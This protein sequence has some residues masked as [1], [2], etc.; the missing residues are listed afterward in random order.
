[1]EKT[2][3]M[4]R[5]K[6]DNDIEEVLE[7]FP[8]IVLTA[9]NK[10]KVLSGEVDIF[11]NANVYLE[12]FNIKVV[13][14]SRYPYQFPRLFEIGN[15]L[16][17]VPDRHISEDG[18]C[19]VCSLQEENLAAQRGMTIKSFF[20]K[21]VLPYLANQLY[22][23]SQ[24]KWANGDF[25]HGDLGIFQYYSELLKLENIAEVIEFLSVFNVTKLYRNDVCFCGSDK[26][27]KR[28]H[29]EV[30]KVFKG[31]SKKRREIDLFELRN[32]AKK[33]SKKI[34]QEEL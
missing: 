8:K 5:S 17:H 26:K 31:L 27:L 7:M 21:Y 24:G 30:Y 16:E 33:M 14:P 22:Y 9:E 13:V 11:D 6:I 12:S 32:L 20:L 2:D 1:L 28:C 15:K 10:L 3:H 18:S 19:C 4:Q 29:E 34:K 23:D 25:H